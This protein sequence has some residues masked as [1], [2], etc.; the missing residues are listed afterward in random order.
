MKAVPGTVAYAVEAYQHE[1]AMARRDAALRELIGML[2]SGDVDQI[3]SLV[4]K[5]IHRIKPGLEV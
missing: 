4:G 1:M 2:N 3:R 5:K